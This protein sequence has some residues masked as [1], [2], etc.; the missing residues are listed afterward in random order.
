MEKELFKKI[1][2]EM[3]DLKYEDIEPIEILTITMGAVRSFTKQNNLVFHY[4]IPCQNCGGSGE[5][6]TDERDKDGNWERGTGTEPCPECRSARD[7]D[8]DQ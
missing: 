5:V 8:D 6:S 2:G 7:I 3:I 4:D 1:L